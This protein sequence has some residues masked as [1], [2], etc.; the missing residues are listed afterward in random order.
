[1]KLTKLLKLIVATLVVGIALVACS[2]DTVTITNDFEQFEW[3]LEEGNYKLDHVEQLEDGAFRIWRLEKGTYEIQMTSSGD[4]TSVEWIGPNCL[5]TGQ[6]KTFTT[7]CELT[8]PGQLKLEN[9]T[10]LG[11]GGPSSIT[12]ELTKL[13]L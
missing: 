7:I 1:M 9:P 12:V 4:G 8:V 3:R 13:N 6:T 10:R 2:V 5:G 11:L